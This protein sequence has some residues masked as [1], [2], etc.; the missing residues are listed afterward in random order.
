M[1]YSKIALI[2][3]RKDANFLSVKLYV[4]VT[5]NSRNQAFPEM[6]GIPVI[7]LAILGI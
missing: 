4:Y 6:P 2:E 3:N 7:V 5:G 1:V